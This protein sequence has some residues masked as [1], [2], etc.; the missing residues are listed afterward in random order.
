MSRCIIQSKC[1]GAFTIGNSLSDLALSIGRRNINTN[2]GCDT[3]LAKGDDFRNINALF[4][5]HPCRHWKATA[6][7]GELS[8]I[9]LA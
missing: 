3:L 6:E 5:F 7:A 2:V 9:V 1:N 8:V 4:T